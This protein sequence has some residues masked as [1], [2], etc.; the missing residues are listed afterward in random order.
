[1]NRW[2]RCAL[3]LALLLVAGGALAEILPDHV[4]TVRKTGAYALGQPSRLIGFFPASATLKV[5]TSE[6]DF[7]SVEYVSPSGK[8]TH[9]L[10]RRT[11]MG[12][13]KKVDLSQLP[14]RSLGERGPWVERGG[15]EYDDRHLTKR[16]RAALQQ[17]GFNWRHAET[18]HFVLH[19]EHGIFA[20]KVARMAEFYYDYIAVDLQGPDDRFPGRSHII[21]YRTPER[22]LNFMKEL[23]PSELQWAFAFASGPS[24]FLQQGRDTRSSAGV[25]AH[26]MTHLIMNRF[27]ESQPP[28]WLNEG[29]AEWYGEFAY[30]S[31]KGTK[32][33]R[34]MVFQPIDQITPLSSLLTA[35]SY[36]DDREEISR[37]YLTSKYLVG[38]LRI[39]HPEDDFVPFMKSAMSGQSSLSSLQSIYGYEDV[40]QLR[41]K[42]KTFAHFR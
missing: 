19:F 27:F 6:G 2:F 25:L 36:P 7:I 40:D 30:S 4:V 10:V 1:M 23:G 26:E 32:K 37:F 18:S 5:L 34:K 17:E 35:T 41:K 31:Y 11:D 12:L 14:I 3:A 8:T 9:A 38:Y 21:I 33:S 28:A 15:G 42:F 13:P 22:W 16:M 29:L 24:L 39:R 20:K